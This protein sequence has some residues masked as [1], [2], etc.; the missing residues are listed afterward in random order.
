M[1]LSRVRGG[2]DQRAGCTSSEP[3]RED[4]MQKDGCAS[5]EVGRWGNGSKRKVI[6]GECPERCHEGDVV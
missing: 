4:R 1:S 3:C 2:S 5:V 6:W